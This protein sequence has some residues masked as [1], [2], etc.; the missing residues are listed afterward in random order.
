MAMKLKHWQ[1]LFKYA[2][3]KCNSSHEIGCN[4]QCHNCKIWSNTVPIDEIIDTKIGY[5]TECGQ[6]GHLTQW[7]LERS[8]LPV[9]VN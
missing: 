4:L 8:M 1:R 7:D 5:D 2:E 9:R 6:C 3:K